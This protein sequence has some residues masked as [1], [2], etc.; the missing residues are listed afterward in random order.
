VAQRIHAIFTPWIACIA[1]AAT[2]LLLTNAAPAPARDGAMQPGMW[3]LRLW[4]QGAKT[5]RLLST[6]LHTSAQW[7]HLALPVF[8]DAD[9]AL[10]RRPPAGA[11]DLRGACRPNGALVI[12]GYA[13]PDSFDLVARRTGTVGLRQS[14]SATVM[15]QGKRIS[16]ACPPGR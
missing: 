8:E 1:A 16:A 15:S 6:C 13:N 4:V 11:V 10:D 5:P 9:C 7:L 14:A 12:T 3:E 2:A